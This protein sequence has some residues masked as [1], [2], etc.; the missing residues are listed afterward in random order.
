M[1][2]RKNIDISYLLRLLFPLFPLESRARRS[3]AIVS[4]ISVKKTIL[5]NQKQSADII[6]ISCYFEELL[7]KRID[8]NKLLSFLQ[9]ENEI[10]DN[11]DNISF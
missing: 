11:W 4:D 8:I 7:L 3:T 9:P 6:G 10:P 1:F 2:S 5:S